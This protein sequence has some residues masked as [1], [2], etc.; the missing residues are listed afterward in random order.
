MI[1][2]RISIRS[3]K[4]VMIIDFTDTETME[5]IIMKN[6]YRSSITDYGQIYT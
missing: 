5:D 1:L 3:S 4:Y 2:S 6:I